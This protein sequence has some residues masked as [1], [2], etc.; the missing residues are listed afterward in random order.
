MTTETP[1]SPG[2]PMTY[3][4]RIPDSKLAVLDRYQKRQGLSTRAAA[5][6]ELMNIGLKASGEI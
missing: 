3:Q 2:I 1:A 4:V 5:A 6:R